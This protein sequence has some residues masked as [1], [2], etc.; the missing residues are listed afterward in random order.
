MLDI[1]QQSITYTGP[2]MDI[3][4]KGARLVDAK[5]CAHASDGALKRQSM[6][7]E[8]G[9]TLHVEVKRGTAFNKAGIAGRTENNHLRGTV[10][11][12][13]QR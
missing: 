11:V 12:S 4:V 10:D 6:Y 2:N 7:F 3:I 1:V 5:C 8:T 9:D 13:K